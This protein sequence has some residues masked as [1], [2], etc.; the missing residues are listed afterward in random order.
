MSEVTDTVDAL[1][2]AYI[3]RT[4]RGGKDVIIPSLGIVIKGDKMG[5]F[6]VGQTAQISEHAWPGSHEDRDVA[7]RGQVV[8]L[9]DVYTFD[10]GTPSLWMGRI[11]ETGEIVSAIAEFELLPVDEEAQP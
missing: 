5:N 11:E 1:A 2:M 7:N 6:K 3:D 4:L 10:D 8:T 9:V